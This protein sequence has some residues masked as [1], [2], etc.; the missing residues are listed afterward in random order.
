MP[1]S[2]HR[3][4]LVIAVSG[5]PGS[6][7]TT[8]CE[9]L[10]VALGIRRVYF[11]QIVRDMAKERGMP[12]LAFQGHLDEHPEIDRALEARQVAEAQEG[13][14]LLEGR[15]SALAVRQAGVP[16]LKLFLAVRPEVQA[17]RLA[18]RDDASPEQAHVDALTRQSGLVRK[19]QGIYGTDFTDPSLYDRVID[20]SDMTPA[21]VYAEVEREVRAYV[22]RQ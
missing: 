9:P 22:A 11:G 10:A 20:T 4:P 13:N 12:L 1:E 19:F 7:K 17:Q 2:P 15:S 21:Q 18:G 5:D 6:G 8:V 16:A 14:V 3:P